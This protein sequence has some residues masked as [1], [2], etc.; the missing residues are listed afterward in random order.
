MH[1]YLIRHGQSFVNLPDWTGVNADEPLTELGQQQAAALA[2]TT[3]V[4]FRKPGPNPDAVNN[5]VCSTL[6]IG[7]IAVIRVSTNWTALTPLVGSLLGPFNLR[8][9]SQLPV[10]FVCPNPLIAGFTTVGDCP[11]QP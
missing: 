9:E 4:Q 8:A 7:C 5:A 10:E 3:T 11:K 6:G 2:V 1:L